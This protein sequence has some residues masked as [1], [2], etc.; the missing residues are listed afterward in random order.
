MITYRNP[1]IAMKSLPPDAITTLVMTGPKI[2]ATG[3]GN[4]DAVEA[5]LWE[6][7]C[8]YMSFTNR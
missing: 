3:W 7:L 6:V 2:L 1:F 5:W 8:V 4:G